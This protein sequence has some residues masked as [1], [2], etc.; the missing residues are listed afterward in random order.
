VAIITA[1]HTSSARSTV[2]FCLSRGRHRTWPSRARAC[3]RCRGSNLYAMDMATI[4]PPAA[5]IAA[6][7]SLPTEDEDIP[8]PEAFGLAVRTSGHLHADVILRMS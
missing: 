3:G 2:S 5:R 7:C 4:A 6:V 8:A 1:E